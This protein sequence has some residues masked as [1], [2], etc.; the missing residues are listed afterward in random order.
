MVDVKIIV[1]YTQKKPFN[2]IASSVCS[3]S[4]FIECRE[5][6][7]D[8]LENMSGIMAETVI[9]FLPEHVIERYSFLR[10]YYGTT[11]FPY[12]EI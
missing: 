7:L 11:V 5:L 9:I 12:K 6:N 4:N 1:G 3:W 2:R 10:D 8:T